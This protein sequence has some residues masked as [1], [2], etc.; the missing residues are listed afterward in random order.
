RR[1]QFKRLVEMILDHSL[2][3]PGDENEVLDSGR[4]RLVDDM[5]DHRPIDD[6]QHLLRHGLGRGKKAGAEAGHRENRLAD[7]LH[8]SLENSLVTEGWY[9]RGRRVLTARSL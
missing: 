4:A 7:A 3:A 2:V 6:G 9:W 1:L 8:V 5:L